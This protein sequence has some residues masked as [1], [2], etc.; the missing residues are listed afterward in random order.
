[1]GKPSDKRRSAQRPGRVERARVK[2]ML[3]R[4]SRMF[5]VVGGVGTYEVQAGRKK[6]RKVVDYC[7]RT[8]Q[9]HKCGDSVTLKSRSEVRRPLYKIELRP[10]HSANTENP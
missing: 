5:A 2:N 7:D 3:N 1:M 9:A 6:Y 4:R 10:L 8:M